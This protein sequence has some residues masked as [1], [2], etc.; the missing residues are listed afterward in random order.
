MKFLKKH[1]EITRYIAFGIGT[2][3]VNWAIYTALSLAGVEMTLANAFSWLGAVI[4]AFITNKLFVFQSRNMK[5]RV[6]IKEGVMFLCSRILTGILE[7]IGP[8]LIFNAGFT[9]S[10]F[11]INGLGAKLFISV[12]V[13]ILNYVISKLAVFGCYKSN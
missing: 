2:T 7:I 8:T 4:F 5:L 13:I 1:K 10:P 11:N 12:F 9:W 3:V 6:V